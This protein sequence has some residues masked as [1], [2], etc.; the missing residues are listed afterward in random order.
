MNVNLLVLLAPLPKPPPR[1]T[2]KSVHRMSFAE[3][4]DLEACVREAIASAKAH[5]RW[6]RV[7]WAVKVRPYILH[8]KEEHTKAVECRR[9]EA[10]K[11]GRLDADALFTDTVDS[12]EPM[13]KV[14]RLA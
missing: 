11:Q 9:I 1:M 5:E 3:K 10:S 12:V 14:A 8:W 13:S 4:Q 2:R 7:V 6:K